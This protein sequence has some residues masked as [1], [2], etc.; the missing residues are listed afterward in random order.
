MKK[1]VLVFS[2]VTL[3]LLS[4]ASHSLG[5]NKDHFCTPKTTRIYFT[6][7]GAIGPANIMNIAGECFS[8]HSKVL[9][10]GEVVESE[11]DSYWG[12]LQVELDISYDPQ[13]H[14][15][16]VMNGLTRSKSKAVR[17]RL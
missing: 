11:Y 4:F 13:P 6:T 15:V 5:V 3:F 7:T 14:K 12:I 17:V 16:Q 2:A 1:G 10:D 8:K 9:M